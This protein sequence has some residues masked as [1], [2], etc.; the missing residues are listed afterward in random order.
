[1]ATIAGTVALNIEGA[2]LVG[3]DREGWFS[4]TATA[5][6]QTDSAIPRIVNE[7]V[8]GGCDACPF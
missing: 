5:S 8:N 6:G 1:M 2:F 3:G 7:M 4:P